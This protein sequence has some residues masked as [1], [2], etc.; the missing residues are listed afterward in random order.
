ML[1]QNPSPCYCREM[2]WGAI[3]LPKLLGQTVHSPGSGRAEFYLR[4]Y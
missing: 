4:R 1:R 2:E 3:S